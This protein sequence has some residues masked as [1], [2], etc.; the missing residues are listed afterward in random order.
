MVIA[1]HWK[2]SQAPNK[3]K[4][5]SLVQLNC[6]YVKI[7]SLPEQARDNYLTVLGNRGQTGVTD[8]PDNS[9]CYRY[10][11]LLLSVQS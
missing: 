9:M 11:R 1:R 7:L 4:V 2:A 8:D 5:L 6:S 3:S 10:Y